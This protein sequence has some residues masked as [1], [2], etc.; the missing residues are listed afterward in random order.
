MRARCH[1]FKIPA[2]FQIPC[3]L[4]SKYRISI[5]S[6]WQQVSPITS[7]IIHASNILIK[8]FVHRFAE[9]TKSTSTR[10]LDANWITITFIGSHRLLT[11]TV[12]PK[13]HHIGVLTDCN[14]EPGLSRSICFVSDS[15]KMAQYAFN[16]ITHI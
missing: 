16:R 2:K 14:Y 5:T 7:K 4:K 1:I 8:K 13:W 3:S 6:W 10:S 9:D 11:F 15:G 12:E